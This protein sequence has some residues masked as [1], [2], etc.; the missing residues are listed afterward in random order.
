MNE[1]KEKLIKECRR[2][3]ESCLYTST[4]LYI[5][6]KRTR[7]GNTAFIILPIILSGISTLSIIGHNLAIVCALLA[8]AIPAIYK[9]L[10]FRVNLNEISN[11]AAE[12]KNLQNRF[13]QA[14]EIESLKEEA[15]FK[16][17]FKMIFQRLELARS[18]GITPPE[19]C[20][21]KARDKIKEGHY[22]FLEDSHQPRHD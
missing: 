12:F 15:Y 17:Y 4:T 21:K 19:W 3:E 8:G 5:W 6:L 7:W 1:I 18:R 14:A 16:N 13:R 2:Q 9:A 20:F 10:D 22:D 11:L